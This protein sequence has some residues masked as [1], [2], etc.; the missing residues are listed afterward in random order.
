MM[1]KY[2][3]VL[4]VLIA[5]KYNAQIEF[6]NN[7]FFDYATSSYNMNYAISL[8]LPKGNYQ[9]A[10]ELLKTD[11]FKKN[12]QKATQI[13]ALLTHN[14]LGKLPA[15]SLINEAYISTEEKEFA[16]LWL[17]FYTNDNDYD[18]L[19]LSF[20][21]KYPNN[22]NPLKLKL[23]KILNY[24][25]ANIWNEIKHKK[26]S[27]LK[28]LDSIIDSPNV[29]QEDK[30][31][32]S[33][34]KLDFLNKK[35]FRSDEDEYPKE[36]LVDELIQLYKNN[37]SDFELNMLKQK[38]SLEK[39]SKYDEIK[40]EIND[41]L[42]KNSTATSTEKVLQ[43]LL[44]YNNT[45]KNI[46]I[47]DLE[48]S[49][50]KILAYEKNASEISKIKALISVFSLSKEPDFGFFM[51]GLLK[52]IPFSSVFKKSFTSALQNKQA[53]IEKIKSIL[54]EPQFSKLRNNTSEIHKELENIKQMSV[55]DIQAF[56]GL[57]VFS[58]YYSKSLLGLKYAFGNFQDKPEANDY[59]S[60]QSFIEFL[61]KNPLYLDDSRYYFKYLDLKNDE[62]FNEFLNR[63]SQ[64]KQKFPGSATI[65]KNG[66]N[67][68]QINNEK[69][70]EANLQNFYVAYFKLAVDYLAICKV[71]KSKSDY[72]IELFS[73]NLRYE[74]DSNFNSYFE[75]FYYNFST[76]SKKECTDYLN[77]VLEKNPDNKD[78][79]EIQNLTQQ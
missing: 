73:S 30:L 49:L 13:Q 50:Y 21:K 43:L 38:L 4:V 51:R 26:A 19:L 76:K 63:F 2:I 44:E 23:R 41:E 61:D 8:A 12:P 9:N 78:L 39:S 56:Y 45:D 17:S 68:L 74:R 60:I 59:E 53:I 75:N 10:Q 69:I 66:L 57:T 72:D 6:L 27:S 35:D 65:L 46:K 54:D 64:L 31:Y 62:G 3:V 47:S 40:K 52:P 67:C 58:S 79:K 1:K 36:K 24:R 33:L 15:L 7:Y 71:I 70:T 5:V 25:D 34:M 16:T 11:F 77:L 37:K 22:Y 42:T 32:F 28:T 14:T 55:E 48:S 18:S 20:Q 29:L